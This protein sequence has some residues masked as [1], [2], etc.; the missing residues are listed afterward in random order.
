MLRVKRSGLIVLAQEACL[1]DWF[2]RDRAEENA[3]KLIAFT[4]QHF[5]Q[6]SLLILSVWVIVSVQVLS[7]AV[8]CDFGYFRAQLVLSTDNHGWRTKPCSKIARNVNGKEPLETTT[9]LLTQSITWQDMNRPLYLGC[10]QDTVACEHNWGELASWTLHS[11]ITKKRNRRSTS[12][13]RTVPSGGNRDT[14]YG[15]RMSQP[16]R[17]CGERRKTCAA[18]PNSRQHVDWGFKHDWS[19]KKKSGWRDLTYKAWL[20]NR[21][22][23]FEGNCSSAKSCMSGLFSHVCL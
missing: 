7:Y 3:G 4:L 14:S 6:C 13:S 18:P 23:N 17:S 2:W 8:L 9:P 19:Q 11:A 15:R 22:D 20:K 10:E 21:Q 1:G 16:P 5:Y 12:S